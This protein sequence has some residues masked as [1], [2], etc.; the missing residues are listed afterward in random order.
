MR[1]NQTPLVEAAANLP[2]GTER[3]LLL[4]VPKIK[5]F[6]VQRLGLKKTNNFEGYYQTDQ[7]GVTFVVTAA[8]KNRLESY[9]WWFPVIGSVPYKGFFNPLDAQALQNELEQAGLDVWIFAAPAYSTLGWFKDPVTSPMLRSGLFDL[10]E[11]LFH[12]MAHERLYIK[13]QGDFNEQLASFVG[14][15]GAIAFMTEAGLWTPSEKAAWAERQRL[16]KAVRTL[17]EA[18]LPRFEALYKTPQSEALLAKAREVLFAQLEN[19]WLGLTGQKTH[20]NNARLLQFQRYQEEDP[21]ILALWN[22][23]QGD[24]P[25]FWSQVETLVKTE[26]WD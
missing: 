14:Q 24:W 4:Q 26:G 23:T 17:V 3:D 10:A 18:Y 8:P 6:G 5:A 16:G 2:V 19:E 7:K 1:L 15:K 21:R 11:T 9:Q 20:F 22:Q 13:G 12:E 25:R